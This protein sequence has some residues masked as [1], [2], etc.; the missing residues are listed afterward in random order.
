[1]EVCE[2]CSYFGL[3][4]PRE[5]KELHGLHIKCLLTF[6]PLLD[7]ISWN[8]Q[9][10]WKP[11]DVNS[12]KIQK[13]YTNRYQAQREIDVLLGAAVERL[14]NAESQRLPAPPAPPAPPGQKIRQTSS[15]S[16]QRTRWNS[17]LDARDARDARDEVKFCQVVKLKAAMTHSIYESMM[18]LWWV[19][20]ESMMSLWATA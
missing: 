16:T 12:T 14:D 20:D 4:H 18:S 6:S 5:A 17:A 13:V 1:M 19:F 11:P 7:V 10:P 8:I 9:S 15:N 2:E 3:P